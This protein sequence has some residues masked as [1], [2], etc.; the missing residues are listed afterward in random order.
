M[1]EMAK[2]VIEW[3]GKEGEI[4]E[5]MEQYMKEGN[6]KIKI[7]KDHD[8]DDVMVWVQDDEEDLPEVSVRMGVEIVSEGETVE[9]GGV[10]DDSPAQKAGL[11]EGDLI[12][13]ING[14]HVSGY[15]GL[16][17]N[18]A[19]YKAGDKIEVRYIRQG[20]AQTSNLTLVGK[21]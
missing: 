7:S 14:Y 21:E 8:T 16:L 3:T 18:L 12:T 4:P 19:K 1:M 9:V 5:G 10:Q 20:K 11:Q 13:E 15:N 17:K 6:M 2:K